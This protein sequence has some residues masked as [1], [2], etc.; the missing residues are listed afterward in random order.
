MTAATVAR[1]P[2]PATAPERR[3]AHAATTFGSIALGALVAC[4]VLLGANAASGRSSY[5]PSGARS[6]PA[7]LAGPLARLGFTTSHTVL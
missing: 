4:L 6:F 7:W 2:A 1:E 5:V 3:S